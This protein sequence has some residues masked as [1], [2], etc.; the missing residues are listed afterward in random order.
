MR[1]FVISTESNCDLSLDFVKENNI[2][3][4]PHYY[5]VEEDVYGDEKELTNKEFYDK[6]REGHKVGTQASNPAVIEEKFTK[7]VEE[8]KDILHISFSSGLS[9]GYGN[10][11][12]MSK[13]VMEA[14]PDS[15]IIVLDTLAASAG[16][17]IM[18]MK[19]L[20]LQKEG[21]SIDEVAKVLEE[22]F[23]HIITLFTVD[24]LDYL[25]RGGRLSKTSA[26]IGNVISLKPI[27]RIN[28]EGKLVPLSKTRGRNKSLRTLVDLMDDYLGSYKDKQIK[29]CLIHGDCEEEALEVK[30]MIK[31]KYGFDDFF[32]TSIGPSIGA[33]SGP[34]TMG[35]VFLGEHR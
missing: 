4:I 3:V 27:L 21:K 23:P 14:H 18:I 11:V 33:H 5:T 28:E 20:E 25:Y 8:G 34:G 12:M 9:G 29:V 30:N 24:N 10:V 16:E 7:I 15:K 1:E 31:E 6:M 22:L 13:E 32:I 2:C 35:I 19:A 26:V 17:G